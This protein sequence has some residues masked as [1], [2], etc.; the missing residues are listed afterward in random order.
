MNLW[1]EA[2]RLDTISYVPTSDVALSTASE[3][4]LDDKD[5][6]T[7]HGDHEPALQQTEIEYPLL[8]ALDCAGIAILSRA[9]VFLLSDNAGRLLC[10]LQDRLFHHAQLLAAST[11]LLW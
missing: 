1:S 6:K 2:L 8:R 9:E 10:Q 7:R 5:L 4:H 11:S 3:E